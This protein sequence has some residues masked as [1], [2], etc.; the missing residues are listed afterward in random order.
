MSTIILKLKLQ[1]LSKLE[2]CAQSELIPATD[3]L[4]A[5]DK[6]GVTAFLPLLLGCF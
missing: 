4:C 6:V 3:E 1:Q 2:V 5:V